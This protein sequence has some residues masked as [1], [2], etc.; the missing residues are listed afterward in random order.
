[1]KKMLATILAGTTSLL[2][3]AG[4]VNAQAVAD[5]VPADSLIYVGWNGAIKNDPLY[6]N[7]R[8]KNI[9]EAS[10]V[11]QLGTKTI[12]QLMELLR[13]EN[14]DAAGALKTVLDVAGPLMKHPT[15]LFIQGVDF[16]DLNSQPQLRVGLVSRAGKDAQ[17][18]QKQI[19]QMLAN[20]PDP[21]AMKIRSFVSGE[22]VAIV[23]GYDD[24]QMALAG[25]GAGRPKSL[26]T[27][28]KFKSALSKVSANAQFTLFV[29][30]EPAFVQADQLIDMAIEQQAAR[31][32]PTPPVDVKKII[33]VTGLRGLKHVIITKG[34]DG[35]E[36]VSKKFVAAPGPR[37]GLLSVFDHQPVSL[38]TFAAV[39]ADAT[40]FMSGKF[41][42]VKLI[43]EIRK[44]VREIDSNAATRLDSFIDSSA[45]FFGA[46][47]QDEILQSLGEDYMMYASPTVGGSG[48][49]GT[50]VVNKL[51]DPA[52]AQQALKAAAINASNWT[53]LAMRNARA[54]VTINYRMVKIG[55]IDVYYIALPIAAPSFAIKDGYLYAGFYPQHVASAA[56]RTAAKGPSIAQNPDFV[57]MVEKLGVAEPTSFTFNNLPQVAGHA[58]MYPSMM[59]LTRYGGFAELFNVTWP[60][61][62]IPPLDIILA[63]LTTSGS[64]SWSDGE[65][66]Y[67]KAVSPFPLADALNEHGAVTSIGAGSGAMMASILLPSLN[68]ARETANRVKSASNL[69][70]IGLAS[71]LFSNENRGGK[72][73]DDFGVILETQDISVEVFVNPR[74]GSTLPP[75]LK[76]QPM[77]QR[78]K[79]VK[80]SSDYVWI[81]KGQTNNAP[82]D[83]VLAYEN[84]KG[85][86]DGINVL[87]GDGHVEFLIMQYALDLIEDQTGTRPEVD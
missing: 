55:D 34:F 35:K 7:S 83:V 38:D 40:F 30:I 5:R 4:I 6:A 8:F 1:M 28:D 76:G 72:L 9:L 29:D 14:E 52:K 54:E 45:I 15:A 85:L 77:E 22:D 61:P 84:P 47:I 70:Q 66:F 3:A 20:S 36:W 31:G 48:L 67:S 59:L 49:L 75:T 65:G 43:T 78:V 24:E 41:D 58:N 42:G 68:R 27:S 74:T 18:L 16:K 2:A 37:E 33:D 86:D 50:V 12:P 21:D 79:W 13:K 80:T 25:E 32:G 57:K 44:G 17:G 71:L 51:R 19:E 53:R 23:V 62:M 60:E 82:A 26:L 39:P 87:F 11:D 64:A 63:N 69:R 56:R 46:N 81:G 73:P 10:A